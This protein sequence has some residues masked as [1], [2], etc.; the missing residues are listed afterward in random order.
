MRSVALFP[1]LLLLGCATPQPR[2]APD[3]EFAI[4]R[5]VM[6]TLLEVVL[7]APLPEAE[8]VA[9]EL[10]VLA[11]RLEAELSRY[12]PDSALSRLNE[13]AG[14]GPLPVP[15]ALWRIVAD[16]VELSS[17]TRGSFDVSVGPLMELWTHAA[18]RGRAPSGRRARRVRARASDPSG[19]WPRSLQARSRSNEACPSI[20]VG[21]PR[22]GR[23]TACASCCWRVAL[24]ALW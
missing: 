18:R 23:S 13:G 16:S 2:A 3:Q 15:P 1:A 7:Y 4:G 22:A 12:D 21:S 24:R 6:G 11:R 5:Y 14:A 20:S 10:V 19:S 9:E 17:T 8:D